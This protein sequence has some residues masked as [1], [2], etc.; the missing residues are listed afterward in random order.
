MYYINNINYNYTKNIILIILIMK[1]LSAEDLKKFYHTHNKTDEKIKQFLCYNVGSKVRTNAMLI[2]MF[3]ILFIYLVIYALYSLKSS[4]DKN[5]YIK[6][7]VVSEILFDN[8]DSKNE[9]NGIFLLYKDANKLFDETTNDYYNKLE[10]IDYKSDNSS[11][12]I[13]NLYLKDDKIDIEYSNIDDSSILDSVSYDIN[14]DKYKNYLIGHVNTIKNK[15]N[16]SL[17]VTINNIIIFSRNYNEAI[18]ELTVQVTKDDSLSSD[19]NYFNLATSY[20]NEWTYDN[21][22][23][24]NNIYNIKEKK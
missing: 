21:Q 8:T 17:S 7:N 3:V 6:Y 22:I 19:Y 24:Y 12:N 13:L 1:Y 9:H 15:N 23:S 14:Y 4:I 10:I 16:Y 20:T 11:N 18:E 5:M 2:V